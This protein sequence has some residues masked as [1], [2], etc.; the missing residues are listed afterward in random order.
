MSSAKK[1]N[2]NASVMLK[3]IAHLEQRTTSSLGGTFPVNTTQTSL[4]KIVTPVKASESPEDIEALNPLTRTKVPSNGGKTLVA[5]KGNAILL[6][7]K[8][9][10]I[11]LALSP[12]MTGSVE[13]RK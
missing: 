2:E 8:S 12:M 13:N 4:S 7:V 10:F 3:K 5:M 9:G 11:E 1:P 6:L